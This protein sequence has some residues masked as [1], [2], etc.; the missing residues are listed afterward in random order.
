MYCFESIVRYSEIDAHN[1]M[2]LGAAFDLM[3]DC[4]T[5]HSEEL[6]IGI[7]YLRRAH[8]AWALSSWQV[9]ISRLPAMGEKIRAYTWPYDFKK[10]LGYRNFKIDDE[11]G[12]TLVCANSIWVYV[13]TDSGRPVR[14]PQ[15]VAARY[16]LE[17]SCKME[18]AGRKI[19]LPDQ[20]EP[21]EPLRVGRFHIDTNRHVNNGKYITMAEEYLPETFKVKEVRAEYKKAA[22]FSDVIFPKAGK[23]EK[24]VTVSLE[25][26]TGEPYA[27]IEFMED[28]R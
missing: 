12:E 16:A 19:S 7:D 9:A 1:R 26:E 4:C 15:E 24:K 22:V 25:N 28:K 2:K 17:P 27:V 5:F 20:M 13:D 18:C 14:L 3:Q 10:S 6:G 23:E 11:R 21:K 8:K